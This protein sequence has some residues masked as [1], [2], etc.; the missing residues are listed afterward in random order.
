MKEVEDFLDKNHFGF[1]IKQS[2]SKGSVSGGQLPHLRD[3][4]L[5]GHGMNAPKKELFRTLVRQMNF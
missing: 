2:F 3:L 1:E 5:D 4:D